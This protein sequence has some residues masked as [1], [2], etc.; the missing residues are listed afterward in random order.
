VFGLAY[1]GEVG[2]GRD[3]GP[4]AA[5]PPDRGRHGTGRRRGLPKRRRGTR[6]GSDRLLGVA[7]GSQTGWLVD[8]RTHPE[9]RLLIAPVGRPPRVPLV[10]AGWRREPSGR[11]S[12]GRVAR[13]WMR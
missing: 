7:F 11:R 4:V 3:P 5:T 10:E 1:A 2:R 13:L 12:G 6:C 9:N 8:R